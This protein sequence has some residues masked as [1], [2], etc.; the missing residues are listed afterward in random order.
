MDCILSSRVVME[1]K[2]E[3]TK[4]E[5]LVDGEK[6]KKVIHV[7]VATGPVC[8]RTW[9][10]KADSNSAHPDPDSKTRG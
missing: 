4:K 10:K 2:C 8:T 1:V 7:S 6:K 3:G 9:M 5:W